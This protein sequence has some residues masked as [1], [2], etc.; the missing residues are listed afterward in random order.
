MID[1]KRNEFSKI[2]LSLS[3]IFKNVH[4]KRYECF[5]IDITNMGE[6]NSK[7][8]NLFNII[9]IIFSFLIFLFISLIIFYAIRK[10]SESIKDSTCRIN[11][12]FFYFKNYKLDKFKKYS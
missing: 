11:I 3:E 9:I 7:L 1:S 4:E 5:E 10:Y 8:M 6:S 12:S 2:S